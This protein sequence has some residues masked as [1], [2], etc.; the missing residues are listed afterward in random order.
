[1]RRKLYVTIIGA[2]LV[3]AGASG[4]TS[5]TGVGN[6]MDPNLWSD[7]IPSGA[8]QADVVGPNTVCTLN[9]STGDWGAGGAQRMTVNTGATLIVEEGAELVGG[10][11][12][13]VGL[14]AD[15][16][17]IQ[18]GGL[19]QIQND[20]LG[21]GDKAGGHGYYIMS[22]GTLTYAG[23]RGDLG[24]G[25]REGAGVF[26]V[27]G[28]APVIQM[29]E[30]IVCE[31]NGAVGTV[32][33]VLDANGV[34]PI[35]LSN[36]TTIDAMGDTTTAALV[37]RATDAPPMTDILLVDVTSDNAVGSVFDTVNG[38]PAVE[39]A[40]V[41]VSGGGLS[42][43]YALTYMGGTGNDIVLVYKSAA[44]RPTV[45][46]VTDS[47]DIN[48]DGLMDD[49][50]VI[51]WLVAEGYTVDARRAYWQTLDPNKIAELNAADLVI[52]SCG[53]STGNYDDGDEPTQWNSLTTPM[54]NFNSWLLR[55]SRWKW[56]NSGSAV[57]DAGAP[58]LMPVDPNHPVFA[59]VELDPNGVVAVLDASVDNGQTSF[60]ADILDVGNG[61]LLASTVGT[62]TTAFIAEWA[63]GVEYYAGAGQFAGGPRMMFMAT[64]QETG[65]PS[66]QG[67]FNLNAAGQ[68]ILRN[69]I[70]YL[71]PDK[72]LV[73]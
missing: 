36:K 72:P 68:Q 1:M 61:T 38:M 26:T 49:Q 56:M 20:K 16:T 48:G 25:S 30:L 10:G 59:G 18:T 29:E 69:M 43:T 53:L 64:E 55:T 28:T 14:E 40:E 66:Q 42:C 63:A 3:C 6:W 60:L 21:I 24:V 73:E 33:F 17:L 67:A 57:K 51:D 7:G 65:A 2:C 45:V 47:P 71:A 11:W 54:I 31:R 34:S 23:D 70:T 52:A 22:G 44:T 35:V 27:I 62:Y 19:V 13:R 15:G 4:A 58:L 50:S 32:E 12:N 9:T 37:V 46:Y 41:T 8:V 39:G 5:F